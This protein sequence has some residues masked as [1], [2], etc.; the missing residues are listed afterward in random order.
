MGY[1]TYRQ[2]RRDAERV[3][4]SRI[5]NKCKYKR[6]FEMR[7]LYRKS[8]FEFVFGY[9]V[10][11]GD[12]HRERTPELVTI[13]SPICM[14]GME[15]VKRNG[16]LRKKFMALSEKELEGKHLWQWHRVGEAK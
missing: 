12:K 11:R 9:Q 6:A 13:G 15:A 1:Q 2:I 7:D 4:E 14:T 16:V 8:T 5:Y 10:V 3:E